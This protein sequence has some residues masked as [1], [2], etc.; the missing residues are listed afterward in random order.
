LRIASI[1]GTRPEAIKM[2]PVV[3]AAQARG[4]VE[5]RLIA[6]GQHDT[7]FDRAVAEFGVAVDARLGSGPGGEHP[8]A[9]VARLR[10][11]LRPVLAAAR[12]DI[13]LVQGDTS[14]ALAGAL[15]GR[16][17]RCRVGHVEAGLRSHDLTQPWP[18]E[19]N[20]VAIDAVADLLFAPTAA[21]AR[22]LA[23]EPAVHGR[24]LVTGNTGIDALRIM[25]A[26]IAAE[27]ALTEAIGAALSGLAGHLILATC[28]RRENQVHLE[29]IAAALRALG[30]RGDATLVI[31]LHPNP[32]AGARLRAMLDGA[33]G[34]RLIAPASYAETVWLMERAS[35]LLTDSGGLQ[36]EAPAIG[37]AVL[38]MRAVTERPEAMETG[39]LKLVGTDGA[40][41]VAEAGALLDHPTRLAAMSRPAFPYGD[42]HAAPRILA[43]ITA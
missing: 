9:Q 13:V 39:N 31:P 34:I 6:T 5:H 20:R 3:L 16:D 1:V 41:I 30:A 22:N 7:L 35:F 43:A 4:Q 24:V 28:H 12:P 2:M 14:S 17:A 21:A 23:A 42:G 18:E 32:A 15:A 33:P 26:R 10:Q 11:A 38:V 36:E 19:G 8:D 29:R 27:P 40:G 25:R 37:R